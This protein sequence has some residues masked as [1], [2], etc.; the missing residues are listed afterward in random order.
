[1]L[2]PK[3][4]MHEIKLHWWSERA[5]LMQEGGKARGIK[6]VRSGSIHLLRLKPSAK[7]PLCFLPTSN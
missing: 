5:A 2:L 3:N 7:C 6:C 1:M 4:Q